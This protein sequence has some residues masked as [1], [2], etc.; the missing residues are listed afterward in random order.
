MVF[1]FLVGFERGFLVC[2]LRLLFSLFSFV[3]V[4]VLLR[5][6]CVSMHCLYTGFSG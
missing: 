6:L 3:W 4:F 5:M 2:A 1:T